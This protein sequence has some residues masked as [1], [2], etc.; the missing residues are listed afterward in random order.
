VTMSGAGPGRIGKIL[1][2]S[3]VNELL[4]ASLLRR[5]R[6]KELGARVTKLAQARAVIEISYDLPLS[7]IHLERVYVAIS[8]KSSGHE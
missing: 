5:Y 8:A 3:I 2:I 6:G 7:T 4:G 1:C